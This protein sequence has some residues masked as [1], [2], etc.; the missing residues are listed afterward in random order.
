MNTFILNLPKAELHVHLEGTLEPEQLLLF[1]QRNKIAVPYD[2]VDDAR[3]SYAFTDMKTFLRTYN[4]A[5]RVICTAYD[6][7]DMTYAYL[8]NIA[9]QGVLHTELSFGTQNYTPRGIKAEEILSGI[10]AALDDGQKNFGI[11]SFLILCFLRDHSEHSA[12]QALTQCKDAHEKIRAVGLACSEINN[13]PDKFSDVFAYAKSLGFKRTAHTGEETGPG[14]IRQAIRVLD[15]NRIDHGVRC[16]EDPTLVAEL[17]ERQLALTVCPLS[18]SALGIYPDIKQHPI[19]YLLEQ[20]VL[21]SLHS[22]DPA[23]FNGY[24][25]QNYQVVADKLGMTRQQLVHIA[26]NSIYSSF[27]DMHTKQDYIQRIDMYNNTYPQGI[28]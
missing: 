15:L 3:A 13:P 11:S 17:A 2:S 20:N 19:N 8:T 7:Y 4:H 22:D 24:I 16:V 27:L 21:V 25:A 23:Y 12:F 10:T 5:L 28:L 26:K 1:A 9:Q 14:A 6:F 18:N